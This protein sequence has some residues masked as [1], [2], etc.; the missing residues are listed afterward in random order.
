MEELARYNNISNPDQLS[1]GQQITV[2]ASVPPAAGSPAA[3]EAT[4]PAAPATSVPPATSGSITH[5]VQPGDTLKSIAA[6]YGVSLEA[7]LKAN[8]VPNPDSLNVG[9]EIRV[10]R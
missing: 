3:G 4:A 5:I 7:L 9:Q 1:I 2:T 8:N 6:R 10:P